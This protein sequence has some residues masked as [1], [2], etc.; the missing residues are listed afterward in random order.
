MMKKAALQLGHIKRYGEALLKDLKD[1]EREPINQKREEI[2]AIFKEAEK[3][4][5]A[6]EGTRHVPEDCRSIPSTIPCEPS[7][8]PEGR[9][10]DMAD[11]SRIPR[12][13]CDQ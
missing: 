2:T 8:H 13:R 6:R 3:D 7:S 11:R 1:R 4:R 12:V 5:E 9:G 10:C